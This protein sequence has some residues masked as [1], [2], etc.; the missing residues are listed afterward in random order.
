[1]PNKPTWDIFCVVID[2]FGDIGVAWRLARQLVAEHGVAVRL[3]VDDL[4]T[5]ST[6]H[7]EASS[8]LEQQICEGV[9]VHHWSKVWLDTEP[10]DVVIEAFACELPSAYIDAMKNSERCIL[11]LNLEYLSA[12]NWIVDCHGLPSLQ[13]GGLQKY[14]FFPGFASGTGAIIR[15]HDLLAR[16]RAFQD[17]ISAREVF[18]SELG[19]VPIDGAQLISLFAYE[20]PAISDWLDAMSLADRPTQLLIPA[21][22][23]LDDVAGWL[24][25]I[26]LGVGDSYRRGSLDITV[27]PFLTQDQYDQLLWCCDFNAVRGEE[28]FVRAQWT[29]KPLVWH[30]YPQDESAHWV[31]LDAF[32]QLYSSNLAV[33]ARSALYDF[34]CAWNSGQGA[35]KAWLC[36]GQYESVLGDHAE[37]WVRRQ[38]ANGDLAGKLVSFHA[39][40]L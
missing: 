15:E 19:I 37:Y 35:G 28:S 21:G 22:R 38:E 11:W 27:L 4:D 32:F 12:E 23:V 6:L 2:N 10:A 13:S 14:F 26:Q 36:L 1:M 18:L 33:E 40:W 34:W 9:E 5:F 7:P 8:E 16:R 20:N 17:S 24:G 3:W 25:V 30:I 39:D 29:G 31:K